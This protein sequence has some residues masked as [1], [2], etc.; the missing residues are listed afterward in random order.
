MRRQD[1]PIER[2]HHDGRQG[3]DRGPV[4]L[5]PPSPRPIDDRHV[6]LSIRALRARLGITAT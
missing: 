1:H 4:V 6:D 3:G 5:R 2:R